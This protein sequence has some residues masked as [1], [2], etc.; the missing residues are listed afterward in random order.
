MN[1]LKKIIANN[2]SE[3]RKAKKLTQGELAEKFNYSDKSISKWE[4]GDTMPDIEIL[5]QLCQFYGVSLD[6]LV[7]EGT[8]ED[9]KK[10]ENIP[11]KGN[12][13]KHIIITC[14]AVSIVW[15]ISAIVFAALYSMLHII[16]WMAFVWAI[17]ISSIVCIVF[18]GIWGKTKFSFSITSILVWSLL[19]S[20]FLE[21][22]ISSNFALNLWMIFIVGVPLQVAIIL[23]STLKN[24]EKSRLSKVLK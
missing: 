3:L 8:I 16:Y 6:Y 20:T 22:L 2:L 7:S 4:H 23:W 19:G 21:C 9:R 5:Y 14:L 1:D 10:Y 18:N 17:P 15:I 24:P 13:Q 12:R 11:N